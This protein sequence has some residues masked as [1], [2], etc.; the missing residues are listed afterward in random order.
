[1]IIGVALVSASGAA[2]TKTQNVTKI[3]VSTRAAVVHYLR[4]IHVNA[5]HAVIQRG[6]RNYAGAHCPG[7][8][9]TCAETK[10]TVVQIAK[11]GGQNR[12]LCKGSK[13]VVVQISGVSHGTYTA[14]RTA[15][16]SPSRSGG[17]SGYCVKTGSGT[18]SGGGQTCSIIQSGSG[19]NTAGIYEVTSKVSVG[20][21]TVQ[22]AATIQQ[23]SSSGN[24]TACVTQ[25]ISQTASTSNTNT[26]PLTVSLQATQTIVIKQDSATG[27][28]AAVNGANPTT[29][30]CSSQTLSQSQNQTSIVSTNGDITQQMNPTPNGLTDGNA[31][32]DIEQNQTSG[33]KGSATGTNSA[34]FSQKTNQQAVANTKAGKHVTQL[35]NST[36]GDGTEGHAFSGIVGTI[37][38]DSKGQSTATV[39]QDEIQCEDA[40]NTSTSGALTGCSHTSDAVT[41]ITLTQTQNGPVGLFT[42][43]AK[44]TARVPAYHKGNGKSLQTG[45]AAGVADIFNLT[46]TSSQYADTVNGNTT[47]L[48]SNIMQGDC[49]SS[50]DGSDTGGSCA[51]S[52]QATLNGVTSGGTTNAGYTAGSI[53]DLHIKCTNGHDSCTATPPPVPVL[54]VT[55]D[56]PSEDTN[57]TFEWTEGGTGATAGISF[58][59]TLDSGDPVSCDSGDAFP[60]GLGDHTF[61][62]TATDNFGHTSDP[63]SFSWTVVPYLTFEATADG[64]SAGWTGNVPGSSIS[65]TLGS[66]SPSTFA[67]ITLH[68]FEGIPLSDLVDSPSFSTNNYAA[69]SPRYVIDLSN[70]DSLWGYPPN[71]GL[72]GTDFAWAINNGNSYLPWSDVQTAEASTT[73]E[74]AVV[75]AD[76]DQSPGTTDVI[77]A[78]SFDG[79]S[80]SDFTN[81]WH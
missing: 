42:P 14:G 47:V 36:D 3:N 34:N 6:F 69:G 37:N 7:K 24:N 50:G 31:S 64:A 51:A 54:T 18:L 61:E 30:T 5:K 70:G 33:F 23:T 38:Q 76:G 9:W 4:S 57:P 75:V 40:A 58:E 35:Q 10:H 28:N 16:A 32:L 46:Q 41:G 43:P 59:C 62:V 11:L 73:I 52:Q 79:Y 45:A 68:N 77:S 63:A 21:Q 26:K 39:T 74:D 72:N 56:D 22:F 1:M 8:H 65:L 67:Q 81:H 80:L 27:N 71:S 25:G 20:V 19:A 53:D 12:Y 66:D 55:P 60:V 15:T 29:G 2:T 49:K 78:L 13:C 48:Q 44:S 17:N